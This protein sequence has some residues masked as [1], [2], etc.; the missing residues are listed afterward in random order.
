[1]VVKHRYNT[2]QHQREQALQV[3]SDRMGSDKE[4]PMAV[5]LHRSAAV[6]AS[7]LAEAVELACVVEEASDAAAAVAS[8]LE[9]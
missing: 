3:S 5:L 7:W 1:M 4:L 9:H 6:V 2:Y 8:Y